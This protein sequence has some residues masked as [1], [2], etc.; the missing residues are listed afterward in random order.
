MGDRYQLDRGTFG[1]GFSLALA[2]ASA[3]S[4]SRATPEITVNDLPPIELDSDSISFKGRNLRATSIP[5]KGKVHSLVDTLQL[6]FDGG[7]TWQN[8]NTISTASMSV[9][10]SPASCTS[11]PFSMT[12]AQIGMLSDALANT[13]YGQQ[14]TVYV[15]G[16]GNFGS[17]AM[18][19]FKIIRTNYQSYGVFGPTARGA[20]ITV[21]SGGYKVKGGQ[22]V[23]RGLPAAAIGPY[24]SKGGIQ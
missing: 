14:F 16:T 12:V 3:I 15:R 10:R 5:L 18:T 1:L 4:C 17:T 19:S 23:A 24:K 8:P 9:S 11:C 2:C 7:K 13:P 20:N 21:L 6:S 22:I